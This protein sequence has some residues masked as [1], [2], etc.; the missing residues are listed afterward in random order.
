MHKY[1]VILYFFG[2]L[3]KMGLNKGSNVI[4]RDLE[5]FYRRHG[6]K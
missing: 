2:T 4:V 6:N 1:G 5:D 3:S